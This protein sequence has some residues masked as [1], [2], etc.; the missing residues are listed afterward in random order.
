M[1]DVKDPSTSENAKDPAKLAEGSCWILL[2]SR[3]KPK[4]IFRNL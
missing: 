3:P 2:P 1:G 4:G